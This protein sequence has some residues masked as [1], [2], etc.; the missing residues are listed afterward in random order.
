M[1]LARIA[2][3]PNI[4]LHSN[5][6]QITVIYYW[7]NKYMQR[8]NHKKTTNKMRYI[9]LADPPLCHHHPHVIHGLQSFD[10]YSSCK[11][12]SPAELESIISHIPPMQTHAV[13]LICV[14]IREFSCPSL[15]CDK[16]PGLN[17][18]DDLWPRSDK[19]PFLL[20]TRKR[21]IQSH[22]QFRQS[23]E[24]SVQWIIIVSV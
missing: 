11:S 1:T 14:K 22:L 19:I 10:D 21:T 9:V 20:V 18:A 16:C 8:H 6:S 17:T 3:L 23:A 13:A 15:H 4:L 12:L 7:K 5:K 2:I 24:F